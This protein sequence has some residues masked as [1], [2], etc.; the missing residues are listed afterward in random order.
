MMEQLDYRTQ[1]AKPD[2][3]AIRPYGDTMN[4]GKVQLS[5]S[6]PVPD[7]PEA[8]EAARLLA[9]KMGIVNPSVV[10][11]EDIGENFTFIVLYGNCVHSVDYAHIQ[12]PKVET[13]VMNFY[14]INEFI[15]TKIGRKI[16]I[17]GACTGTDAHTVGIDAI[18][19]MKGYN[20]EYGLE[21]YPEIQ[22]YNLGSQV[23][24]EELVRKAIEL[25]ADALL[26]SQV[27][28]QKDVH[29]HNLSALVDLLEAEGLRDK[30]ILVAG[31]P[32]ITHELALELGYDAGFGP[33][34]L[35]PDVA[36]FVVQEMV[37]RH[38]Q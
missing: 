1:I 22:A 23:E 27:V 33:G 17:L 21:R 25:K 19:N 28:T 38:L 10:H 7:G 9:L 12:V 32:R 8:V 15:R 24:N 11:H 37:A 36:S 35:A 6:L 13:E 2:Y 26:V 16:T 4:D 34:T 20:G 18:M 30:L 14:E 5:F 29:L 31:G 3:T